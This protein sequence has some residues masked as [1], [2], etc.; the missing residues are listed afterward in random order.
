[1]TRREWLVVL[2]LVAS[3]IINYI[4]RSNLGIAAPVLEQQLSLTPLQIGSLLAAFSWTYAI[5][6]LIGLAGWLSDR[7]PVGLVLLSGY[8]VWS[9]ATIATGLVSGFTMLFAARLLLGAG[10]SIAY[11]CYSRILAELP[12]QYRGRANALIDAGTKLG[13]AAGAFIGGVLLV[14]FGW[15]VLFLVL[16]VGGLAWILPW[17]KFMPRQ[18]PGA[19]Q[20]GS[21]QS[22]LELLGMRSAWGSFLGLFCGNYFY[23]FLLTW[24][25]RYLVREAKMPLSTT[26]RL[27]SVLFLLIALTTLSTGWISDRL[28]VRGAS[29]TRVRKTVLVGGLSVAS[30]IG[31]M[32]VSAGSPLVTIAILFFASVGY[33]AYASN[34]W[35]VSQTLAGPAMAGRWTSVQNGVGNLAGIA[36]PWV[37]G[38]VAQRNGNSRFAFLI[39]GTVALI[40]AG[41]WAFLVPRVEQV[42][43]KLPPVAG[44]PDAPRNAQP[45]QEKERST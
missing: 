43:W 45:L 19:S 44:L 22:T 30:S 38:A 27:T 33:G 28:I 21:P 5:L 13:P 14:H 23:Y 11:P 37:A 15:R 40:G 31:F 2:L 32:V 36:A 25:P 10:E 7:F 9:A 34:H 18:Q 3:V 20:V 42:T 1:M 8:I 6:Q 26:T 24:L 12:Q 41:L 16:G 39:S 29:V 35:A 4:D 17:I